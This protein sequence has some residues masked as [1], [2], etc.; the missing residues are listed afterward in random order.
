MKSRLLNVSIK[1]I[2]FIVILIIAGVMLFVSYKKICA[3]EEKQRSRCD[4][5]DYEAVITEK[6]CG[7]IDP[8]RYSVYV[9]PKDSSQ[10]DRFH[11]ILTARDADDI[12]ISWVDKR[13]VIKYQT[14]DIIMV[15]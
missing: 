9:V 14:A 11:K 1:G 4:Y 2:A 5:C 8:N 10:F 13:L 6:S 7:V 15:V 3:E 12:D